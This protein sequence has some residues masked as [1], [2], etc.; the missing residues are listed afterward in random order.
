MSKS[1]MF[2][3]SWYNVGSR[4]KPERYKQ[5]R[6]YGVGVVL[7]TQNPMDIEYRALFNASLWFRRLIATH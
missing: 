1:E 5:A 2:I 4:D 6:T 7:A 3:G